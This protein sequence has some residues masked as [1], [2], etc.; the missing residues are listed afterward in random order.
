MP[1]EAAPRRRAWLVAAM[2]H[3]MTFSLA[4][5]LPTHPV[6]GT[7]R[8]GGGVPP[9]PTARRWSPPLAM[10]VGATSLLWGYDTAVISGALLSIVPAYGLD[11]RPAMQG[12]IA[13]AATVGGL[14]GS[15]SG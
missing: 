11:D 15:T 14:A 8:G 2:A 3:A 10:T 7:L 12:M 9:A 4:S 1:G 6:P 13:A 5:A